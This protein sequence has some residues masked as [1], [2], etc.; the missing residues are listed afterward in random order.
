[1]SE[2]FR[3]GDLEAGGAVVPYLLVLEDAY[4][5]PVG[6][7]TAKPTDGTSGYMAGGLFLDTAAKTLYENV[8][9]HDSCQFVVVGGAGL[10]LPR[11]LSY[12]IP[13]DDDLNTHVHFHVQVSDER[14]F[15]NL[16][17]DAESKTSQTNWYYNP[18]S[19][20]A[21]QG[22]FQA[23]PGAGLLAYYDWEQNAKGEWEFVRQEYAGYE[24]MYE[25]PSSITTLVPGNLYYYRFRQWDVEG[26]E[27]GDWQVG[28]F[29]C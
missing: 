14:D 9:T 18:K 12:I 7:G 8:G 2:V 5:F 3:Y 13:G 16:L 6:M 26:A 25:I 29:R 11:S 10:S 24:A 27:Y 4:G 17:V 21:N 15:S 20:E 19:G 23:L 1:M 22:T 28:A